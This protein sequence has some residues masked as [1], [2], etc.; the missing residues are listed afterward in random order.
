MSPETP[1]PFFGSDFGFLFERNDPG[2]ERSSKRQHHS[3]FFYISNFE[4][5]PARKHRHNRRRRSMWNPGRHTP[6]NTG[7]PG[8][9]TSCGFLCQKRNVRRWLL[10]PGPIS[11]GRNLS[12]RQRQSSSH[13]APNRKS[14]YKYYARVNLRPAWK[15][16]LG[17]FGIVW[18]S[19]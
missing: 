18:N 5:I 1:S 11:D 8:C 15:V 6:H 14:I 17:L 3:R 19:V 4:R 2:W 7:F 12:S 9:D 13:L 16:Q 10:F